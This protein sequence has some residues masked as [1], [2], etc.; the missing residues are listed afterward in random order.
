[1][2]S[3]HLLIL[4]VAFLVLCDGFFKT[5][6]TNV[7]FQFSNRGFILRASD[8]SSSRNTNPVLLSTL[9]KH[10]VKTPLKPLRKDEYQCLCPFHADKNPSMGIN[11]EKGLY[12]CFSC[13]AKGNTVGF[14]MALHGVAFREAKMII[15]NISH[16]MENHNTT[17]LMSKNITI[18]SNQ[19]KYIATFD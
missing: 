1:M 7:R 3:L 13:G 6:K 11:D 16:S 5:Q 19:H 2:G 10:Y 4:T 8:F 17:F 18:R 15:Q 9:V 12:H 14:V